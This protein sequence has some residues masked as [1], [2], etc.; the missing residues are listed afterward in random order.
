MSKPG[1]GAVG[2]VALTRGL[3]AV[4]LLANDGP[5]SVGELCERLAIRREAGDRIVNT[6]LALGFIQE[7]S[8]A[9][10]YV[11]AP[12][13]H[14]LV[15]RYL[16]TLPV[17]AVTRPILQG[18]ADRQAVVARF[19]IRAEDE[20]LCLMQLGHGEGQQSRSGGRSMPLYRSPAGRA[21]LS[22]GDETWA[23]GRPE[24]M[25]LSRDGYLVETDPPRP[26]V[27]A[28]P[29]RCG[30]TPAAFEVSLEPNPDSERIRT[31]A[32][33][34]SAA[35]SLLQQRLPNAGVRAIEL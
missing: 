5:L 27:L 7:T 23:K 29:V 6:L 20:A 34:L 14:R 17:L 35:A 32:D 31:V 18:V 19:V 1:E 2:T 21:I 33:D 4:R 28:V 16:E 22:L 25:H 26:A 8:H 15:S 13:V 9:D 10:R 24:G 12:L 3:E 11:P 30:E